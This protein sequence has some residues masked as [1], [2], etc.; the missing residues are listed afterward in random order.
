[1]KTPQAMEINMR[2]ATLLT[3]SFICCEVV[4]GQY[5][6]FSRADYAG[7]GNTRIA[8]DFNGD[9]KL[10]IAGWTQDS[11]AVMLGNGDGTLGPRAHY[12]VGGQLQDLAAGDFTSDGKLDLVVTKV[13]QQ[14]TMSLLTGNADGTFN[15]PINFP[16]ITGFDAPAVIA[17]DLN[18]DTWLD[19]V[20][21]HQIACSQRR[22]G[23]P[24]FL[25]SC[26]ETAMAHFSR[27]ASSRWAGAWRRLPPV[28]S[29]AMA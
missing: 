20:I 15:A 1:M 7:V 6:T 14:T 24:R 12:F 8:A 5:A 3:M 2:L 16:N 23:R 13:D 28:T 11:I 17:T 4:L 18:N 26:W 19:V 10:D 25:P 27:R 9:G 21:A 22:A 29:T